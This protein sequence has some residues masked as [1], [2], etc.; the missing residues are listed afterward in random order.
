[1]DNKEITGVVVPEVQMIEVLYGDIK[2]YVSKGFSWYP[3]RERTEKTHRDLQPWKITPQAQNHG[4]FRYVF[5]LLLFC[6][7][8]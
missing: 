4:L 8:L 2:N 5:I 7:I 3:S 6:T 1:M